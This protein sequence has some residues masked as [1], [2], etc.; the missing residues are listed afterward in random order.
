MG[1]DVSGLETDLR[2]DHIHL[3]TLTAV[4][5]FDALQQT[6]GG[7]RPVGINTHLKI[8]QE[9]DGIVD[10]PKI[11]GLIID[12]AGGMDMHQLVIDQLGQC[13][14]VAFHQCTTTRTFQFRN[15]VYDRL[16]IHG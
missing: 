3:A 10:Q 14:E 16:L 6:T 13:A 5:K 8:T 9:A 12:L 1:L 15:G 7:D 4:A 2:G 11:T